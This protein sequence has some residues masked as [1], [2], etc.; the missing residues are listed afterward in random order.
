ML[1]FFFFSKMSA[2]EFIIGHLFCSSR[3]FKIGRCL[4]WFVIKLQGTYLKISLF[5]FYFFRHCYSSLNFMSSCEYNNEVFSLSCIDNSSHACLSF[6]LSYSKVWAECFVEHLY[7][8]IWCA[9]SWSK[10][11]FSDLSVYIHLGGDA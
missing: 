10:A 7:E 5:I 8:A 6:M 9:F 4:V 3:P 1:F 11:L 2:Q